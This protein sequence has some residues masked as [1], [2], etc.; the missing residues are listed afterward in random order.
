MMLRTVVSTLTAISVSGVAAQSLPRQYTSPADDLSSRIETQ[1]G[2][3]LQGVLNNIGPNGAKAPGA[4]AGVI[5]ASPSTE[6]P[7]YYFTWTRDAAL[8]MK[9]LVDE[10][11]HGNTG[12]R[13]VI[14]D[15]LKAQAILQTVSNPS[16]ALY[17][18]RGLGEPKFYSNE[19]RF[20][21]DWGRPQRDGP[22]LRATALIA[23]AR[24]LLSTTDSADYTE[25]A[26]EVWPVV[27]N[28]LNYVVQYWNET[29]FD[30]W[31]E[32]RG[33]SFFTTAVQHRALVE[34][35]VL[36]DQL[37]HPTDAYTAQAPNILCFLQTFWNGQYAIANINSETP[38]T[39]IDA[40]TVLTSIA[41]FDPGAEC[42]NELFQPCSA[43]ALANLQVY[44][45]SFR[46]RYS[47]N[48]NATDGSAIATGR[49]ASDVYYGGQAWYLT[50][51]AVAEQL[52]DAI[53][54]W[55]TIKTLTVSSTDLAFWQSI[56]PS[57][58]LG[59]Y[60]KG[61][62]NGTFESLVNA[63]L[64]YADGFTEVGLKYTPA[65]GALSEQFSGDNGIQVSARDLTWSYASFVTL[66]GA[67]LAATSDYE[68]VPSWGAPSGSTVPSTCESGS[69]VGQYVPA[70]AA[71]APAGAG[72]CT[73]IVT[74]NVNASTFFGENLYLWGNVSELGNWI[75]TDA[76]AGS[77]NG[78]TQDRP[79]WT[80][81]VELPADSNVRYY[82]LRK[83]PDGS[84]LYE[85]VDRMFT[86]LECAESVGPGSTTIEDV[87]VGPTGTPG[88]KML[89]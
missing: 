64:A 87:W 60:S 71:G 83:E 79:L 54:Q 2:I 40:N 58:Q 29:G 16:G 34:G 51:F 14:Q 13:P 32:V 66:R 88:K 48:S 15:Y 5:I 6:D 43:W 82:Y 84:F 10:F 7:N 52:Y 22:A 33:S 12:L 56:Y 41:T 85:T 30:L 70:T 9:M 49:Y 74:F 36:G 42:D 18:G 62:G 68:Q 63:A 24:W 46:T 75:P 59:T 80:F 89:F 25:V 61:N 77:A 55:N 38:R 17:S 35:I 78:Y 1:N 23:Y 44:V 53:Q 47:I 3:S 73:L 8:T 57:A 31:E 50:T 81:D 28:D 19:T 86:N 39:G 4:S 26:E 20:N 37:G 27:Q 67:R 21:G 72:G 69:T 76:L 11:I 65:S 45:D